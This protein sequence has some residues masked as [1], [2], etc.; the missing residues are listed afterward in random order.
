MGKGGDNPAAFGDF[1]TATVPGSRFPVPGSRTDWHVLC[2]LPR[3]TL[4]FKRFIGALVLD[5]GAFE[6]IESDRYAAMQS[7]IVVVLACLAGGFG[8]M[9][10][11]LVG[12]GGFVTGAIVVLG[13]WLVWVAVIA[14]IGTITFAEPQ[15]R[16]NLPELLRTLG[17]A[18]AP[19]VFLSFAAMRAAAPLVIV[20]VSIWMIAAAVIGI[21]QALDYRST[22]RAIA[23]CV[24]GWLI[25]F[26]VIVAISMLFTRNVS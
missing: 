1:P 2:S 20:V 17:F 22:L 6:D 19:A 10:L 25:S 7:V 15:T 13:A 5:P 4:F 18:A 9:G 11:E 3:M 26:G 24:I 16:S 8:A 14:S 12:V 21:R 23:V